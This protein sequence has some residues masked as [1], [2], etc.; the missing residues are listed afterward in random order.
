MSKQKDKAGA[1]PPAVPVDQPPKAD[2]EAPSADAAAPIITTPAAAVPGPMRV[3]ASVRKAIDGATTIA[4]L[5]AATQGL[6]A[7]E[8]EG[9]QG[10]IYQARRRIVAAGTE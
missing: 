3:R 1:A 8:I 9:L 4:E 6:K 2:S 10:P 5:T 7:S